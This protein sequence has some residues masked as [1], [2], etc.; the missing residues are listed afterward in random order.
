MSAQLERYKKIQEMYHFTDSE[1]QQLHYGVSILWYECSKFILLGIILGLLGRFQEYMITI[2]VLLPLRIFSG[3]IHFNH[4]LSCFLF[5]GV[6]IACPIYLQNMVSMP[7]SGQLLLLL[8]C[9][10]TTAIVGPV[11]SKKRPPLSR[12]RYRLFRRITCG[13]L[14]LYIILFGIVRTFPGENICLLVIVLQTIQLLCAKMVRKGELHE[15][16]NKRSTLQDV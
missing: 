6:F 11:A 15:K 3:G 16:N 13:L 14:L 10:I 7:E 8:V 12:E 9:L 5:T 1:I 4:Y 2:L